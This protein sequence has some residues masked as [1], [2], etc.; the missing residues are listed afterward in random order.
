MGNPTAQT[1]KETARGTTATRLA[2]VAL[3]A[4]HG[5]LAIDAL[6][7]HNVTVDEGVHLL[8]GILAWEDG[9]LDVYRVNP[10]LVKAL[11]SLPVVASRPELPEAVRQDVRTSWTPQ[12]VQFMKANRQRYQDLLVRAR[13]VLVGLSLLAGWLVYRWGSELFGPAAGLTAL[14]L[15]AVCPNILGW[16]GVCTVDLGT[17]VFGLAGMYALRAYLR[18][19][20]WLT[21]AGAGA[22]LGLALLAKLTLLVLYPVWLLLWLAVW[23]TRRRPLP[24]GERP[25]RWLHFLLVI[26]V[27][28]LVINAGYGFAGTGRR[29]GDFSFRCDAL[30]RSVGGMC[31]NRFT[32]TGLGRLPVPL[33]EAFVAGLDEQKS[34]A[35]MGSPVYL[36]G[37][38]Q[39]GGSW[40]YY[41][42]VLAVKLPLGTW[43]LAGLA[44]LLAWGSPRYR[45]PSR[46]ELLLWLPAASILVLM[47]SQTGLDGYGSP[48]YLLP[49]FPFLFIGISRV[50]RCLEGT[51]RQLPRMETIG[52][53]W[54]ALCAAVPLLALA[55]NAVAAL[56]IHPHYLSYFNELAGGPEQGWK[57]LIESN[58]D[59]G[60]DL[61]F[62]KQWSDEHPEARPLG[63][64]AYVGM[65]P[66]LTGLNYRPVPHGPDGNSGPADPLQQ[67]P[68]PGW[69]AVSVN[70]VCGM[71]CA[72]YDEFGQRT[73]HPRHAYGYF[74]LFTPVAKAGYSIFIY[75]ITPEEADRAR[76]QLGLPPL[77][78]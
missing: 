27:S 11:F 64:A 69:Y 60:Q 26:L 33:P 17:A 32:G 14:A 47:S 61:L 63:L 38:W 3:L 51:W 30:T 75:H 4:L 41:L 16:A 7:Q 37:Q 54:L 44:L 29:L 39:D 62:L 23:W 65:Q 43:A 2:C 50:G 55:W 66:H 25:V 53:P 49:A 59:W 15:W 24:S 70:L 1:D 21:A 13:C 22:M 78:S 20:D 18:C 34:Y 5:A 72:D 46:E 58:I 68:Q 73:S 28:V 40:F 42:Y 67:G 52:R 71:G 45:A 10:P 9:R 36:R 76:T 35:D 77:A 6:R 31:V 74:R 48:R 19:P 8:S 12:H 57:H 56:R